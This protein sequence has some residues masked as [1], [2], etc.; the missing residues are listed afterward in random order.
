MIFAVVLANHN[1]GDT[2]RLVRFNVP[3]DTFYRSFQGRLYASHDPTNSVIALKGNDQS[4]RST[5]NPTSLSS[6]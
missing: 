6:L 2:L 5:A 3:L 1:G 4:S